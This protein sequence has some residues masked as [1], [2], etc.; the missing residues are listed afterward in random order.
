MILSRSGVNDAMPAHRWVWRAKPL[1]AIDGDTLDVLIDQG[2][3]ATRVERIRLLHVN[4]PER[5]GPDKVAARAATTF[6]LSWTELAIESETQLVP[7]PKWPLLIE[8]EKADSFGRYLG[9]IWRVS[10][11]RCLNSDLIAH[12]LAVPWPK[13]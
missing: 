10:D 3:R 5:N 9:T 1:G 11:G 2:W 4:T 8:T 6:V 12:G 7:R 13:L